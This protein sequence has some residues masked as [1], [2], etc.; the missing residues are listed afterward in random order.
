MAVREIKTI[1]AIDGQQ[2]YTDA[3]KQISSQQKNLNAEMKAAGAQFD[4]A[5][6][7]Q[8]A[9]RTKIDGLNKQI[10]LQKQKIAET[11]AAMEKAA[12]QYGENSDT[13]QQLTRDYHYAEA[14]LAKLQKQLIVTNKELALQESKLKAAGEAAQKAGQKLQKVGDGMTR[15]GSAM[16]VAVTAPILAAAG[17]SAK[18]AMDFESAFAG[19]IKTVDATEEQLAELQTGIREMSKEVPT[20]ATGIAAVAE[21]AGQLGIQT[22]N[23][24]GFTRVMVDL[25]EATN[26]SATE[27][28]TQLAKFANITQMSQKDF[29]KLG[30]SIVAL[31]NNSATTEADIVAMAMR[32]AG[33]G[34]QVGMTEAD[35]VGLS[36]ALSSVGIEAE[37]GGSAM[38]KV[39]VEIQLAVLDGGKALDKFASVA[40]M[41]AAEFAQAFDTDA[42]GAITSFVTGLGKVDKQGGSAIAVL[43]DM[44]ITE[45]RMRDALLRAAGAGEL[46]TKSLKLSS[47]AWDENNALTKEAAQRYATTESQ[48]KIS[49]NRMTDAAITIGKTLLPVI[50]DIVEDVSKA[51]EAFGKMDPAMQ[52]A[53][54]GALAIAAAIGPVIG[55]LGKTT[56]GVGKLTEAWGKFAVKAAEKGATDAMT[57]SLTGMSG[58]AS[59]AA[60]VLG[61][62]ALAVAAVG[63]AYAIDYNT[64][65]ATALRQTKALRE[66][67]ESTRA[68]YNDSTSSIHDNAS[69]MSELAGQLFDLS[70]KQSRTREETWKMVELVNQLNKLYPELG[71]TIDSQTGA[72]NRTEKA[73]YDLIEARK[74]ELMLKAHEER[75][76]DLYKQKVKVQEQLRDAQ[77]RVTQTAVGEANAWDDVTVS[78]LG[79]TAAH[80]RAQQEVQQL[81]EDLNKVEG[82]ISD[83][84]ASY[85]SAAETIKKSTTQIVEQGKES[86]VAVQKSTEEY[87]RALEE[88]RQASEEFQKELES[89]TE[90]HMD[91]MGGLDEK[92]IQ[93]TKLS[94][95]EIKRNLEKQVKDFEEWRREIR[96]LSSKVPSDVMDELRALG[97]GFEP[98]IQEL[99]GMTAEK[100]DAWIRTWR[101][102]SNAAAEA[103]LEEVEGLPVQMAQAGRD[104]AQGFADGLL[105]KLSAV[106]AS[107]KKLGGTATYGLRK[108]LEISSPSKVTHEIGAFAGEGLAL[109]LADQEAVVRT[110]AEK[111]ASGVIG[112]MSGIDGTEALIRAQVQASGLDRQLRATDSMSAAASGAQVAA[113]PAGDMVMHHTGELTVRGVND[114]G[115]LVSATKILMRDL[116][117]EFLMSGQR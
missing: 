5:G 69:M 59:G 6:D 36:A 9:L 87:E 33:A 70:G 55:G 89:A 26:L 81:T 113:M 109:G 25:G 48:L 58:A 80:K 66:E 22:E 90:K 61:P 7:K 32:L 79:A 117:M 27:G 56:V 43:Q 116:Q 62:L 11:R 106:Q 86:A 31:G 35:I 88:R 51:A 19:V 12:A 23:V 39:M 47:G 54:I 103:A 82:S 18:A 97:P 107:A 99:N 30:S 104:A 92:G 83:V 115:E 95:K 100:L 77:K 42:A 93:K 38:S 64:A 24:L 73:V 13:T 15:V 67:V 28:A 101:S 53:A 76:L 65:S 20:A 10:D 17:A 74:Q 46:M 49:K 60:A 114:D 2:K 8:G 21:A 63:T 50:A 52:K 98:V 40:G 108:A 29:D 91:A 110:E 85:S 68:A 112:A 44:E 78:S 94:A 75:L 3:L 96:N 37:A 41:S 57:A 102:K 16:T 72:L 45:V 34:K 71:I 111:L 105:E 14:G 4:L 84:D 1:L